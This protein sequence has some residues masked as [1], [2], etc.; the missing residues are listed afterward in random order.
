MLGGLVVG[1]EA[2]A[3]F[4]NFMV[5]AS[6][7]IV[8]ALVALALAFNFAIYMQLKKPAGIPVFMGI[9][10]LNL[11][12]AIVFMVFCISLL[13]AV[14]NSSGIDRLL[15][16]IVM[17]FAGI[18][19]IFPLLVS[20]ALEIASSYFI[21]AAVD[22]SDGAGIGVAIG[23]FALQAAVC[24]GAMFVT[25]GVM[26]Y[27]VPETFEQLFGGNIFGWIVNTLAFWR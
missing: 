25:I 3:A 2:A 24:F 27:W 1:G 4:A 14:K 8:P 13:D 10:C 19:G 15:S 17:I 16:P 23:L 6:Y 11:F 18:T 12:R 26:F 5:Y 20:A 7:V 22:H 21:T 9:G